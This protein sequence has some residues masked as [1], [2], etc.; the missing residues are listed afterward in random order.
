MEEDCQEALSL[1]NY[2]YDD[3]VSTDSIFIESNFWRGCIEGGRHT[4]VYSE[5]GLDRR[6]G[7]RDR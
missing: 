1:Y 2:Y 3:A 4:E 7:G 5:Y 6:K